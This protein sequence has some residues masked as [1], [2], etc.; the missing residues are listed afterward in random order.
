MNKP[1]WYKVV[2]AVVA[3]LLLWGCNQAA[4]PATAK[5]EPP[6]VVRAQVT[7]EPFNEDDVVY[8]VL[9]DRFNDGNSANNNQGFNEYRPGNL[10]FYQGGDW[11]GLINQFH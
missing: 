5:P 1:S 9:T 4:P 8:M 2:L 10:K 11:Q 6:Q 7:N 3:S